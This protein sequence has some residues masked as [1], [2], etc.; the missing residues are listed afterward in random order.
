M[1]KK[2]F[3]TFIFILI[4]IG[5]IFGQDITGEEIMRK[6]AD[7]EKAVTSSFTMK[8]TLINSSG[9]TRLRELSAYSKKYG[10]EEKTVMIFLLPADVKGVG[11]LSFSYKES[12]KNDDR[13]LYMPAMKK[14]RRITGSSAQDNFMGTDFTYDDISGYKVEDYRH[15]LLAEEMEAGKLCWKVE[16]VPLKKSAYSKYISWIDK[17]SL[18]QTKSEFYDPQGLLLKILTVSA[19]EKKDNIWT[20][21]KMQM[22]NVQKNHTTVIENIKIEFN[23]DIPDSYFRVSSLEEGKIR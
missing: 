13:W 19:I 23:K 12:E 15:T 1:T 9:N 17:E 2:K 22:K 20:A 21:G 14:S 11:Y 5:C 10:A 6:S 3:I 16:S 18:I 7:R 4:T 8:M